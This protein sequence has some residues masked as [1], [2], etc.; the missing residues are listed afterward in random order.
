M[1][2]AIGVMRKSFFAMLLSSAMLTVASAGDPPK[3]LEEALLAALQ[4]KRGVTV[5][6]NGQSIGG[7]VTRVERGAWIELR[8]QE[9]SRIV[10]RWNRI[11]GVALP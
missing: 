3:G 9:F 5:Y 4:N 7:T 2:V 6:V 8:N 1:S 10:V 11:D